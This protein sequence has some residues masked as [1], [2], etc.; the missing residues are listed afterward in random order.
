MLTYFSR[1]LAALLLTLVAASAVVFVVLEVLPGDVAQI[2]LGT[3]ARADTLAALR[4]ELGLDR[5]A[6]ERYVRWL[7]GLVS[8]EMGT[9]YTYRVPVVD[10]VRD[11]L[12]V[13][14]PLAALAFLLCVLIALPAGVFA[15]QH[16]NRFGDWGVMATSH[17][18][19]AIPNFWF[20]ILLILFFSVV[21]GWFPAGGFSGWSDGFGR[22]FKALI[23]PSIALA[24]G[25]AAILA[26]VTRGAVLDTLG[27]DF[28]RTARAKGL[29]ATAVMRGHVLRNAFIPIAT[30]LGLQFA[31]LVGG[32]VIVE[33]VF[34]LPGVGRL[35][36]QAV[37][38]RD[39]IVVRDVVVMLA[40][41]VIVVNFLVDGAY[42]V[43]DPRPKVEL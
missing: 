34:H 40:S 36:V 9:S 7:A 16:H 35:L 14:I 43:I 42:A 3:E 24:I 38:Q 25:E 41:F 4:S 32:T 10:L 21:L 8:G 28:V 5:P 13:T 31:F 12:S 6:G 29:G 37:H 26:R 30:I 27:E 17:L 18:V 33:N 2:M 23:L 22:G 15:A 39:L 11:R 20:A 19:L 1:R